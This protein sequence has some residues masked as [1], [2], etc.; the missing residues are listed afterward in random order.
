MCF[1]AREAVCNYTGVSKQKTRDGL[2]D[3]VIGTSQKEAHG[4]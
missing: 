1:S 2:S 4:H 3:G